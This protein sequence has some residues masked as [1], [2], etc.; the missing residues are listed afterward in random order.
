VRRFIRAFC[1][2]TKRS[3]L[4][5]GELSQLLN[6]VMFPCESHVE[7][8]DDW[9]GSDSTTVPQNMTSMSHLR[10]FNV[11]TPLWDHM[12]HEMSGA[13]KV[14]RTWYS[15][16]W[17]SSWSLWTS[18]SCARRAPRSKATQQ[19]HDPT[20]DGEEGH[21]LFAVLQ[22]LSTART[23]SASRPPSDRSPPL[24]PCYTEKPCMFQCHRWWGSRCTWWLTHSMPTSADHKMLILLRSWVEGWVRAVHREGP[25][26]SDSK[27]GWDEVHRGGEYCAAW[28]QR[29]SWKSTALAQ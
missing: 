4:D 26:W 25:L 5:R 15:L 2:R 20:C 8:A 6:Y 28:E 14:S 17:G 22:L 24:S 9:I 12:Q 29:G 19:I 11:H 21:R 13:S 10:T 27:G 7:S 23:A 18:S 16:M 3:S 1:Y